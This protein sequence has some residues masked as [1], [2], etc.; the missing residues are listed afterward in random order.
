MSFGEQLQAVRRKNGLTQEEFAAQLNVSRQAVSKWETGEA[1]PDT[2]KL[3][4]LCQILQLNMEYL[5]FGKTAASP[6]PK[7]KKFCGWIA[8][9]LAGVCLLTGILIGF[10]WGKESGNRQD[11]SRLTQQKLELLESVRIHDVTISS[12]GKGELEIAILP[13]VLPEGMTVDVLCEDKILGTTDT[14]SCT[15][16]GNFYRFAV[17]TYY[18]PFQYRMIAQL[19]IDGVKKQVPLIDI[20]GDVKLYSWVHRYEES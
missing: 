8:A 13:S 18:Q 12:A 17:A 10:F 4:A 5:V 3:I 15:F 7:G 6:A 16:D 2:D 11:N 14:L 20:E 9:L 1:M 19:T